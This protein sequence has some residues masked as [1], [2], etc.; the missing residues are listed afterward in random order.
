[1]LELAHEYDVPTDCRQ[2]NSWARMIVYETEVPEGMI[3]VEIDVNKQHRFQ[4]CGEY[5]EQGWPVYSVNDQW[6]DFDGDIWKLGLYRVETTDKVL[7]HG[8]GIYGDYILR[9]ALADALIKLSDIK[10]QYR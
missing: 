4:I 8:C 6:V 1:M 5:C 2:M 7:L 9:E 10:E 3:G